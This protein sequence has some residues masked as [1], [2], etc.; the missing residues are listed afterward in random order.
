MTKEMVQKFVV[1]L[2]LVK[3]YSI[4]KDYIDHSNKVVASFRNEDLLLLFFL[5]EH[6]V[7][8]NKEKRG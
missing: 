6:L 7:F 3:L 5:I 4:N 2:S 1:A 8:S